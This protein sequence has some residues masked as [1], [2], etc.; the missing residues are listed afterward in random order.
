MHTTLFLCPSGYF[1][2]VMCILRIV[3]GKWAKHIKAQQYDAIKYYIIVSLVGSRSV[4]YFISLKYQQKLFVYTF[5]KVYMS[6]LLLYGELQKECPLWKITTAT[7]TRVAALLAGI[8][9]AHCSQ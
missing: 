7:A 2:S 1:L 6:I 5:F 8:L 3:L 9:H 4:Y